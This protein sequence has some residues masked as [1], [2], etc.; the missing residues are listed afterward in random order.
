M[1]NKVSNFFNRLMG[2]SETQSI[3][4]EITGHCNRRC[5]Y[6]YRPSESHETISAV[7]L[8]NLDKIITKLTRKFPRISFAISG[9]EPL[10]HPQFDLVFQKIR[11]VDKKVVVLSNLSLITLER[12]KKLRKAGLESIQMTF[13][14]PDPEEHDFLRGKGDFLSTLNGVVNLRSAEIQVNAIL[15]LT[16]KNVSNLLPSLTMLNSLGIKDF[17]INRY[18][19]SFPGVENLFIPPRAFERMMY[20]LDEYGKEFKMSF[21]FGVPI[22]LCALPPKQNF[23]SLELK[24]FCPIGKGEREY[25]TVGPDGSIRACNHFPTILGNLLTQSMDEILEGENFRTLCN[26]L[27][28]PPAFCVGCGSWRDCRGGCRAASFTWGKGVSSPDPWLEV[29]GVKPHSRKPR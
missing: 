1:L 2:F 5:L 26:E 28:T 29:L 27:D 14:S 9:G 16:S 22:P 8:D 4:L 12:A 7:S 6:C 10:L 15:L 21:S 23:T 3:V 18:N 11:Y 19:A 13:L 17:M 25:F 20:E 24:S